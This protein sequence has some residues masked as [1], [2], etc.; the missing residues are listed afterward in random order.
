MSFTCPGTIVGWT[1]AGRRRE[2]TQY[3]KLQIWRE[4]S[5]QRHYYDKQGQDI[6]VDANGSACDIL[7]QTCGQIFQCRLRAANRVSVKTGDIL[8]VELPPTSP[9]SSGFDLFFTRSPDQEHLS[10]RGQLSSRVHAT[11][12]SRDGSFLHIG[13]QLLVSLEVY[14]G[15]HQYKQMDM[16]M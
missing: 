3:P 1:V 10:F 4:D 16:S 12:T 15:K 13:D 14:Q 7:T 8:G 5:S 9:G 11:T 6:Q 2:G